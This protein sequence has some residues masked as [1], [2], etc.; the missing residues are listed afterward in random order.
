MGDR[1]SGLPSEEGKQD[2]RKAVREFCCATQA[3]VFVWP[4]PAH[5]SHRSTSEGSV[6]ERSLLANIE[7][8]FGALPTGQQM[9]HPDLSSTFEPVTS[10]PDPLTLLGYQYTSIVKVS[11]HRAPPSGGNICA[12]RRGERRG[13]RKR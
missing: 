6:L 9:E 8:T 10:I 4:L 3:C 13:K 11:D 5:V 2:V 1:C 7:K 12:E